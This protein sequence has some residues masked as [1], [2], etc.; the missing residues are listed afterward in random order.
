MAVRGG[1]KAALK[2][3]LDQREAELASVTP[4][5]PA[6]ARVIRSEF[7]QRGRSPLAPR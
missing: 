6:P 1:A 3:N 7:M 4:P 5:A 2:L